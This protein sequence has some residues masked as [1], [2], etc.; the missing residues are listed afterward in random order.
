MDLELVSRTVPK[1]WH[2][3]NLQQLDTSNIRC[4]PQSSVLGPLLFIIY[5]NDID[6]G[7][8][9]KISKF[10]YDTRL[11]HY[12]RRPDEVL[13]LQEG[14]NRLVDLANIWEMNFSVDK[15]AVMHIDHNNIEHN[16]T[17]ANPQ[18]IATEEQRDL[19][20]TITKDL[21]WQKSCKTANKVLG[22][23]ASVF[24]Y[25]CTKLTLPL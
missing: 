4:P 16:C 1:G 10:A 24:N 21:K 9:S 17:M 3:P 23:I 20:I 19:G 8:V 12:S 18:L 22:F 15:C 6:N 25:K 5:I 11:C 13:E 7:I 2:Q 14:F